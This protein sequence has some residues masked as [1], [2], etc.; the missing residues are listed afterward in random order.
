MRAPRRAPPRPAHRAPA[1]PVSLPPRRPSSCRTSAKCWRSRPGKA[2]S[3]SR[4]CPPTSRS[5]WPGRGAVG[6]SLRGAKM[7]ERVGVPVLG[8]V[9]NMSFYVCPHCGERTAIFLAGGGTRLADELGVPLLGEVPLQAQLADLA[10]TGRPI[11]AAQP[12]SPA[13]RALDAIARRVADAL[14]AVPR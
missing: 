10:D 2:A 3:A 5:R 8:V 4:P 6:D 14:A 13:A 1:L 11:V 7:F 12:D 9:E